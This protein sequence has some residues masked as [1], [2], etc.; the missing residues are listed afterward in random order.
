MIAGF[1]IA[2]LLDG[3]RRAIGAGLTANR[4]GLLAI[5]L[6][7]AA[8]SAKP[9]PAKS[10]LPLSQR[11]IVEL[12]SALLARGFPPGPVDGV[13]GPQTRDAVA[14]YQRTY[15]LPV[16][17]YFDAAT[18]AA[19]SKQGGALSS[20]EGGVTVVQP[21]DPPY[22]GELGSFL[23]RRYGAAARNRPYEAEAWL[24]VS[25]VTLGRQSGSGEAVI[26]TAWTVGDSQTS[27]LS[28][29]RRAAGGYS[30]ILGP[31]PN[32]GF[33]FPGSYSNDLAD[34]AVTQGSGHRLWR[35][36]GEGYR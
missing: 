17:G 20:V 23:Q 2:F 34:V 25:Q 8:C 10:D 31:L 11:Q 22:P 21:L 18:K 32:Q 16:S 3:S 28:I 4:L 14:A 27:E 33:E 24:D 36:D 9:P 19:L 7:L 15:S 12:Q 30:A 1:F 5:L 35:F 29:Y 26:V 13:I 6:V